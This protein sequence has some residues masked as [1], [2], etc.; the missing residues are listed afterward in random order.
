MAELIRDQI[1]FWRID[2]N[3]DL[4]SLQ[5]I[6]FEISCV[7]VCFCWMGLRE[8]GNSNER[9]LTLN[10]PSLSFSLSLSS[11]SCRYGLDANSAILAGP[12]HLSM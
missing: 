2:L 7:C 1:E 5:V 8:I 6:D 9:C 3:F 11:L 12:N 4:S 10:S